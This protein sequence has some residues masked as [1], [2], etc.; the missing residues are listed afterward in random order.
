MTD[1]I[2]KH[3]PSNIR[4]KKLALSNRKKTKTFCA[5]VQIEQM[6]NNYNQI[7]CNYRFNEESFVFQP[8]QSYK[9]GTTLINYRV[10]IFGRTIPLNTPPKI[11]QEMECLLA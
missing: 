8:C 6:W 4:E 7:N 9:F 2:A 11:K 5:Y 3:Q 1:N 10:V